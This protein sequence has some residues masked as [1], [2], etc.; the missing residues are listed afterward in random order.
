MGLPFGYSK[1]SR[2]GGGKAPRCPQW[3][4][5]EKEEPPPAPPPQKTAV[6]RRLRAVRQ[7]VAQR[8][9]RKIPTRPQGW[10]RGSGSMC[11]RRVA[12]GVHSGT[13]RTALDDD[14]TDYYPVP[15]KQETLR[16][17]TVYADPYGHV[18]VIAKRIAQTDDAAGVLLAV[19]G[20]ARRHGRAQALLAR[21]FPLRAGSRAR[22][23]RLQALPPDRR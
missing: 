16:P 5:I 8:P 9:A 18:L 20:A 22:R 19:D 14:N 10:C 4:N 3:W 6:Q 15:L 13:G 12:N 23:P 21:Q 11:A 2:G 1:C 7:P 17:G